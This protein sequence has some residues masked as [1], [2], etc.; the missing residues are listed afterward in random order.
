MVATIP[1]GVVSAQAWS[2]DRYRPFT[3]ARKTLIDIACA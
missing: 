2:M 1:R 3:K